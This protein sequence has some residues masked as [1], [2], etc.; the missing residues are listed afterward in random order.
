[1]SRERDESS[2]SSDSRRAGPRPWLRFA[3]IGSIA[4][5]LFLVGMAGVWAVKPFWRSHFGPP[6]PIAE[7]LTE[8]M[9]A[10]LPPPDRAILRQAVQ[11]R[12]DE[13]RAHMKTARGAQRDIRRALGANPFDPDAFTAAS[14]RARA[15]RDAAQIAMHQAMR[16]AAI[17]MSAEGR[18]KLAQPPRGPRRED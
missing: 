17:A 13:I 8:R 9:A 7:N 14:N 18:A 2:A 6:P 3:L 10:H 4:I 11:K 15:E 5:N 16:E 12:Q 1:M